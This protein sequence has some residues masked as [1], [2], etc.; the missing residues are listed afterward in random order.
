MMAS[1]GS[2]FPMMAVLAVVLAVVGAVGSATASQVHRLSNGINATVH[3]PDDIDTR[4]L[5]TSA[6]GTILID[7]AGGTVTLL[8]SDEP[9]YPFDSAVVVQA[10]ASMHG[11][12]TEVDVEVFILDAYPAETM[13]SFA[14][15]GAIFLAPGHGPVAESTMAYITTHEMGHV[16]TWAFLDGRT[17]RWEAY[18]ALRGLQP[19]LDTDDLAHADLPREILAEDI[20]FLFGG[21][22]ARIDGTIENPNLV[23][24]NQIDGLDELLSGFFAEPKGKSRLATSQAFPNPCNPRTT[25]EMVL[26]AGV[27]TQ[28]GDVRLSLFDMRGALVRSL[29]GGYVANGRATL[30]WDGTDQEGRAAASGRYHYVMQVVGLTAS[31]AVTLLR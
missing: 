18:L 10:L 16:L 1:S 14:R 29:D 27:D 25:I 12:Q 30:T 2:R 24:P 9:V 6:S 7:P 17:D 19:V 28:P 13:S 5:T 4:L 21:L 31:G 20:R 11:F 3:T 8:T 22:L 23:L 26:P 15:R